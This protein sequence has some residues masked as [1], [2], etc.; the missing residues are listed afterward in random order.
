[1][2]WEDLRA[3]PLAGAEVVTGVQDSRNLHGDLKGIGAV[4]PLTSC[5]CGQGRLPGA[6]IAWGSV[7]TERISRWT[8][9]ESRP[10]SEKKKKKTQK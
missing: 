1:M 10:K 8:L 6:G 2:S 4:A 7:C 9:Q 3:W 5:G